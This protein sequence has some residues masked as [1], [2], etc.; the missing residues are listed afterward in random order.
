MGAAFLNVLQNNRSLHVSSSPQV[1]FQSS[2]EL[3]IATRNGDR[4]FDCN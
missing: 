3:P 4:T 1:A 2:S